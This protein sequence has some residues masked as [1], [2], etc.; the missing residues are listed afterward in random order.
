LHRKNLRPKFVVEVVPKKDF[1]KHLE[2]EFN[3]W[4]EKHFELMLKVPGIIEAERYQTAQPR[5]Y[6]GTPTEGQKKYFAF[7]EITDVDS[8]DKTLSSEER[9]L[10]LQDPGWSKF[11]EYI[12]VKRYV[13]LPI[14]GVEKSSEQA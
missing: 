12:D 11:T 7:Y 3:K 10:A 9:R 8:I 4:Y 1:P 13:Y 5:T 6:L 14:Y 2:E